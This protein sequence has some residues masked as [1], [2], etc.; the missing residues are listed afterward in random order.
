VRDGVL[1]EELVKAAV[2]EWRRSVGENLEVTH[3]RKQRTR[4]AVT[5]QSRTRRGKR[6]NDTKK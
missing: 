6:V 1:E 2:I 3:L 4:R 5:A